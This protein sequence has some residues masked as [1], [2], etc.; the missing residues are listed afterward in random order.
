MQIPKHEKKCTNTKRSRSLSVFFC[1]THH[2]V[3]RNINKINTRVSFSPTIGN[4]LPYSYFCAKRNFQP[5][6]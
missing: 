1:V 3:V 5:K 6:I 2:F 4:I